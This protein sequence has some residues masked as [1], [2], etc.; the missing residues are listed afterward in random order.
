MGQNPGYPAS[1]HP[2]PSTKIG[3]KLGGEFTYPTKKDIWLCTP[4]EHQSRWYMGV[5]LVLT[6]SHCTPPQPLR[7][8]PS[9]CSCSAVSAA[10]RELAS[11]ELSADSMM[12]LRP[13]LG[14]PES[15]ACFWLSHG[16]SA[17][18]VGWSKHIPKESE[19]STMVRHTYPKSPDESLSFSAAA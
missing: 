9:C 18:R 15:W 5:P 1:E 8:D 3:P 14:A 12:C 10:P 2:N 6:H 7:T 17:L 4:G 11:L 13:R 19:S 16:A